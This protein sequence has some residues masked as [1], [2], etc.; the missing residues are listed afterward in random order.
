MRT[1][2]HPFRFK[3]IL[4]RGD[5]RLAT[6]WVTCR[7]LA[8]RAV[9]NDVSANQ[10]FIFT[11]ELRETAWNAFCVRASPIRGINRVAW[12]CGFGYKSRHLRACDRTSLLLLTVD[13]CCFVSGWIR[14]ISTLIRV[15][16][17]KSRR[18]GEEDVIT[19]RISTRL[20]NV[21]FPRPL[22]T[23]ALIIISEK[24]PVSQ[25]ILCLCSRL[26]VKNPNHGERVSR[27]GYV[28]RAHEAPVRR[29]EGKHCRKSV[30]TFRDPGEPNCCV[31]L[32]N[33][34]F[35]SGWRDWHRW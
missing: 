17:R 25:Y 23:Q 8:L 7:F 28:F 20:L 34:L 12:Y 33:L 10:R 18:I 15:P 6:G 11:T 24:D 5:V 9:R 35:F 30:H 3:R 31:L 21:S 16:V 29:V 13:I 4:K 14:K 26:R 27:Q 19:P 32:H 2:S 22:T 1:S